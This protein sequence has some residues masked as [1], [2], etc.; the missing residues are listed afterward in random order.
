MRFYDKDLPDFASSFAG[1]PF[2]RDHNTYTIKARYGTIIDSGLTESGDG[3]VQRVRLTAD[4]GVEDY[5]QGRIDR[6]SIGWYFK[7]VD[8]GICGE[9]HSWF[10]CNHWPGMTYETEDG[11]RQVCE[12]Y[13]VEPRGKETSA[14]NV[15]AVRGTRILSEL[16]EEILLMGKE[17]EKKGMAQAG[18]DPGAEQETLDMVVST[19]TLTLRDDEG[20]QY[21]RGKLGTST[22]GVSLQFGDDADDIEDEDDGAENADSAAAL[23]ALMDKVEK[24]ERENYQARL[25]AVYARSGLSED[26][27]A[28]IRMAVSPLAPAK[29]LDM[30]EA[31][32]VKLREQG[33]HLRQAAAEGK[34]PVHGMA[35]IHGGQMLSE[36]DKLVETVSFLMGVRGAQTPY[37]NLRSMRDVYLHM[38]GDFDWTANWE[39]NP[40]VL[41]VPDG[42]AAAY[43]GVFPYIIAEALNKLTIQVY[44]SETQYR[45]Y[46]PLTIV[47]PH[48]GSTRDIKLISVTDFGHLPIVQEAQAYSE[49][50]VADA[51]ESFGFDKRGMY[52]G[53]TLEMI[54]QDDIQA[55][56]TIPQRLM[57]AAIRTRS[58]AVANLFTMNSK[59]GPTMSDSKALFHTDHGNLDTTA[60]DVNGAAWAAARVAMFKMAVPGTSDGSPQAARYGLIPRYWLGPIDLYDT[61]LKAFGWGQ[62]ANSI[63]LPTSGGTA[64]TPNIYAES[65]PNDPRPV[66]IVVPEWT[67]TNDW[68][69][70]ADPMHAPVLHFAYANLQSGG[71]HQAPEIF[72]PGPN[73]QAHGL[74]FTNDLLPIKIRDW[75][76][77]GVGTYF[78]VLK[79]NVT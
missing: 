56:Q 23:A 20:N 37:R 60:F 63:G 26:Q 74:M 47:T 39:A 15:P 65:R 17:A 71:T 10:E 55:M 11:Q 6:F 67:D 76:G 42:L 1:Q 16:K 54:R 21:V 25:E 40:R 18:D 43:T 19:G 48:D 2:L 41:N 61:A 72:T 79:R 77:V 36:Y 64:Q 45:W 4:E 62:A 32:V 13:F 51:Q 3:F 29:Q 53:I 7:G 27:L 9:G 28:I 5:L 35:P 75:W 14:V 8:C 24:L 33:V 73:S 57:R 34:H 78:G 52:V 70:L 12:L 50:G 46:E 59:V 30:A 58:Y 66:P 38:T 49:R 69:A 22:T 31:M 68:A 44:E